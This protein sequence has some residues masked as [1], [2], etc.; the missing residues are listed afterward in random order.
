MNKLHK[1]KNG[2]ML[3]GVCMGLSDSLGIDVTVIR[4][5]FVVGAIL[6]GSILFWVYLLLAIVLPSED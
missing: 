4:L 3:F 2:N 6:T 5:G 1:S